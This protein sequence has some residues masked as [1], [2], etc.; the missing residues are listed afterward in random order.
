MSPFRSNTSAPAR[1][2]SCIVLLVVAFLPLAVVTPEP[3]RAIS[4][5]LV[6]SQVYGGGGNA[7]AT[8]RND[9]IEI[10]NRGT[11]TIDLTGWSV[12]YAAT[13]G[14]SWSRTNLSGSLAPGQYYLVQ[15][16]QG[17]GGTTNLPTP[18]A[19]GTIA[20]SATAGKVV[21]LSTQTTIT[22]GTSCPAGASIIDIVGFGTGTNCVEGAPTATLSN[23]TAALRANGGLS[24]TDSNSAD[25]AAGAPNP[26]NTT[27]PLNP[28]GHAA[29][30]RDRPERADRPDRYRRL[31]HGERLGLADAVGPVA[32]EHRRGRRAGTTSGARPGRP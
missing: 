22:S 26:R 6:V 5:N 9:F 27:S 1:I 12:Q 21:L 20:M 23:A 15:E 10:L 30:H 4:T 7:G 32:V 25:F 24:D 19:I 31:V 13:T 11:T 8:Y 17:A 14:T 18:D 16:A 28:T 2:L 3:V 29:G